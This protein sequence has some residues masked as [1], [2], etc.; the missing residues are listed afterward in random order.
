MFKGNDHHDAH[1]VLSL[2]LNEIH[3]NENGKFISELFEGKLKS[4]TKCLRCEAVAV[5]S[6]PFFDLSLEISAHTSVGYCL[7]SFS[8]SEL[9]TKSNKYFCDSCQCR[10]EALRRISIDF[11]PRILILH[12]K[13]FK[14]SQQGLRKL[15]DRV[16]FSSELRAQGR[17]YHLEGV[18]AHIGSG[19][20]SGHYVSLVKVPGGNWALLDDDRTSGVGEEWIRNCFHLGYILVYRAFE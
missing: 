6:E 1:E 2:L 15:Q 8:K 7:S 12:L 10:Q 9:L 20:R 14:S 16:C 4:E 18:V 19:T 17:L 13:R 3:E 5:R 11:L